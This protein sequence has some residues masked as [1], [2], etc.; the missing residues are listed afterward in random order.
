MRRKLYEQKLEIG[1]NYLSHQITK[2][3]GADMKNSLI[4]FQAHNSKL[5]VRRLTTLLDLDQK[6]VDQLKREQTDLTYDFEESSS[7]SDVTFSRM[8]NK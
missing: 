4:K 1:T 7:S 8:R 5:K 2:Q 3:Q 6:Q